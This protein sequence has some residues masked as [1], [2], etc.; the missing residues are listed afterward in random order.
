MARVWWFRFQRSNSSLTT[1]KMFK[2]NSG[3]PLKAGGGYPLQASAN[4]GDFRQ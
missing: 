3:P 4:A 1:S 2:L